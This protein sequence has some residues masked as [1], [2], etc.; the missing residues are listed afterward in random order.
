[1]RMPVGRLLL[2]ER[3]AYKLA[4]AVEEVG[5]S[6]HVYIFRLADIQRVG[7]SG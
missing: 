3:V 6:G 4:L 1:M 7:F 2:G 5:K